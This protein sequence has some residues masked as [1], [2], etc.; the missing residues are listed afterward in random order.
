LGAKFNPDCDH[1]DILVMFR[2]GRKYLLKVWTYAYLDQMARR[3]VPGDAKLY[4]IPPD[5]LLRRLER[6]LLEEALRVALEREEIDFSDDVAPLADDDH[7]EGGDERE[8]AAPDDE[9]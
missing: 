8:D 6:N 1:S 9:R 5:L 2:D 4:L 3:N 7:W